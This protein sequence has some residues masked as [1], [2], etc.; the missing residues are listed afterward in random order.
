MQEVLLNLKRKAS[1]FS[2]SFLIQVFL[3][4]SFLACFLSDTLFLS[5]WTMW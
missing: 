2:V 4:N 3:L 5:L 1:G